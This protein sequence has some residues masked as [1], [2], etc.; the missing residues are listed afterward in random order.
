MPGSAALTAD[1]DLAALLDAYAARMDATMPF[2]HPRYAGQMLKAP[3]PV[4]V[5]A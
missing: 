4:A 1:V 2:F 3:H 5:A